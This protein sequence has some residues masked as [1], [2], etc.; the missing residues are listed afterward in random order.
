MDETSQ[1]RRS[2]SQPSPIQ[3]LPGAPSPR[4]GRIV[5]SPHLGDPRE[6][7]CA[8]HSGGAHGNLSRELG[9]LSQLYVQ[10]GAGGRLLG[11]PDG[12]RNVEW[13]DWDGYEE[14]GRHGFRSLRHDPRQESSG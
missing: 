9:F 5:A 4:G 8:H 12:Q 2:A 11:R 6:G 1:K 13:H 7:R 10:R 14:G 3:V